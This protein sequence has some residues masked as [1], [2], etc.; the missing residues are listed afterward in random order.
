[1]EIESH[2]RDMF[3]RDPEKFKKLQQELALEKKRIEEN[4][5]KARLIEYTVEINQMGVFNCDKPIFFSPMRPELTLILNGK[6]V[7]SNNIVKLAIF[8]SDLSSVSYV[9]NTKEAAFFKGV[10]KVMQVTKS[11]DFGLLTGAEFAKLAIDTTDNIKTLTLNLNRVEVKDE[12]QLR[13]MLE[14]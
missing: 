13:E 2:L 12:A 11:G 8:N 1:M 6:N 3:K 7:D 4:I 9:N 10:N 5:K 14:K